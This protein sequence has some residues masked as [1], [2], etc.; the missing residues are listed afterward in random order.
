MHPRDM[1]SVSRV[2]QVGVSERDPIQLASSMTYW[3]VGDLLPNC[4]LV[5][6]I[7]VTL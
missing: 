2:H 6:L 3:G 5:K 4:V 1:T 7:H